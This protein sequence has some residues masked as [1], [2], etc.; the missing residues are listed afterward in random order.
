MVAGEVAIAD[1]GGADERGGE[2]RLLGLD[3]MWIDEVSDENV[4]VRRAVNW[5]WEGPMVSITVHW[6][7]LFSRVQWK[8]V[9]CG[10]DCAVVYDCAVIKRG[11][12]FF[13]LM[14]LLLSTD[15]F[16]SALVLNQKIGFKSLKCYETLQLRFEMHEDN[17]IL[18]DLRGKP[19]G[20]NGDP[21]FSLLQ[22]SGLHHQ[23]LHLVVYELP[24]HHLNRLYTISDYIAMLS[25][26][27]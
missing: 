5:P 1:G 4:R 10:R 20:E 13:A 25:W 9:F 18:A 21:I 22:F 11:K 12:A 14:R 6:R 16:S 15:Y 17:I 27:L 8:Q 3:L 24:L 7:I 2:I 26:S 19:R 23:L